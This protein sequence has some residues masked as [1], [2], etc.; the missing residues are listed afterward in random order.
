M[1][2]DELGDEPGVGKEEEGP[3]VKEGGEEEKFDIFEDGFHGSS[4]FLMVSGF[5]RLYSG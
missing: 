5:A 1:V 2:L 4:S 3:G